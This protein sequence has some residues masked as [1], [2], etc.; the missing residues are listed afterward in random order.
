V[1][2]DGYHALYNE[3]HEPEDAKTLDTLQ[4]IPKLAAGDRATLKQVVPS[5]HFTEPPPR[6]SEASLV[7]EL[8]RLGIG[9]AIHLCGHHFHAA[10]AV[11]CDREGPSLSAHPARGDCVEGAEAVVPRGF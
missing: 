1:L 5:Q 7:K 11:V 3:A 2:F 9:P 4:P 8:E 10:D 6:Y